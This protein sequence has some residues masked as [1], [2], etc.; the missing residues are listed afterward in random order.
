MAI[1]HICVLATEPWKS[2]NSAPPDLHLHSTF[3]SKPNCP[4]RAAEKSSTF[5]V[6]LGAGHANEAEVKTQLPGVCQHGPVINMH[7]C[8]AGGMRFSV[9]KSVCHGNMHDLGKTSKGQKVLK[10]FGGRAARAT[11]S[12]LERCS[13]TG[14]R[15][16]RAEA[17]AR[18]PAG[19][20]RI[21][22]AG[23]H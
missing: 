23:S 5:P 16:G 22:E 20:H 10:Q 7:L 15:R 11:S 2:K 6:T 3:H 18:C 9:K 12:R 14:C 8:T 4:L 1:C 17:P 19:A 13:D 21:P